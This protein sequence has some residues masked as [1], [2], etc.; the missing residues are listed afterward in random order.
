MQ[1]TCKRC[2]RV[3]NSVLFG[4][5]SLDSV[6]GRLDR[7]E[8]KDRYRFNTIC[9]QCAAEKKQDPAKWRKRGRKTK[10]QRGDASV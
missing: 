4:I 5:H 1:L 8:V 3:K 10:V 9:D 2:H 7:Q 6:D